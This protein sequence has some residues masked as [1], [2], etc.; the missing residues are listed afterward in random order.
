MQKAAAKQ[1]F[2]DPFCFFLSEIHPAGLHDIEVG[3]V[4]QFRIQCGHHMRA[5]VENLNA[6][7]SLHT[8]HEFAVGSGEIGSPSAAISRAAFSSGEIFTTNVQL[9]RSR[10]TTAVSVSQTGYEG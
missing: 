7:Q 5:F 6:R 10:G 3:I 9:R 4:E 8:P 2:P 1:V